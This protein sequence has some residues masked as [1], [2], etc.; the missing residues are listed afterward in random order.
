ME[1]CMKR[2]VLFVSLLAAAVCAG[3]QENAAVKAIINHY[4][5]RNFFS[6]DVSQRDLDKIIQAGIHAP[7][8]ANRQPWHFTVV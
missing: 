1:V 8:A 4:A 3:A 5:A 2:C 7:S 6:G